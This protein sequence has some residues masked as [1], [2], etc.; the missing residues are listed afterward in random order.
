MRKVYDRLEKMIE[1]VQ[2]KI[3]DR[4]A[5]CEERTEKWQESEKA[6]EYEERTEKLREVKEGLDRALLDLEEYLNQG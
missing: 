4:E 3:D 6:D 2:D 5:Y 1:T